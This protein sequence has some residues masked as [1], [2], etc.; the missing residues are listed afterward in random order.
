MNQIQLD[1]FQHLAVLNGYEARIVD[2]WTAY[3]WLSAP[4]IS[5]ITKTIQNTK[6]DVT[7][8][9]L[10]KL[11]LL[12]EHGGIMI[13]NLQIIMTSNSFSWLEKMF[14]NV[15]NDKSFKIDPKAAE[16]YVPVVQ[17]TGEYNY[18]FSQNIIA[19][20]PN[21]RLIVESFKMMSEMIVTGYLERNSIFGFFKR[22]I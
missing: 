14:H 6:M 15:D 2:S 17:P 21:S 4:M 1:Y 16:I 12:M 5:K 22:R 20:V 10:L 18:Y 7:V 3:D 11:G 19:A 8:C 13:G 9:D